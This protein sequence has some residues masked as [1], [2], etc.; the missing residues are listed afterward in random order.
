VGSK[1]SSAKP[2]MAKWRGKRVSLVPNWNEI[3]VQIMH[4]IVRAKFAQH[5]ELRDR[6]LATGD[7][8]L[9]EGNRWHDR[10]WGIC[11]CVRCQSRGEN[12]L[13]RLLMAVREEH[14][15]LSRL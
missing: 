1:L 15:S 14:R 12:T 6:L 5:E 3:R 7:A 11:Y 10:F 2:S 8:L 9:I 4:K 13:G